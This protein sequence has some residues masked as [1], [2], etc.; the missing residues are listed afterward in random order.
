MNLFH[1]NNF[2]AWNVGTKSIERY[3][4]PAVSWSEFAMNISQSAF[5]LICK[6]CPTKYFIKVSA[7]GY[8]VVEL[9]M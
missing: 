8:K 5:R 3:F 2:C 1:P 4:S 7:G 9:Y 6:N